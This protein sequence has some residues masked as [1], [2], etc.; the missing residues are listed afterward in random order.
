M[1]LRFAKIFIFLM[2]PISVFF[3]N[4]MDLANSITKK[5]RHTVQVH[6]PSNGDYAEEFKLIEVRDDNGLSVSFSMKVK[7]VICFE[8]VCKVIPIWIRWNNLGEYESYARVRGAKLE[9]YEDDFF[10]KED[11]KKLDSILSNIDSPFRDVEP[12]QIL[13]VPDETHNEVD[14]VSGATALELDEKDTVPGAAL[15]C[16]T[17]WHWAH[18]EII[19]IIRQKF[20]ESCDD[21]DFNT[22]L[23]GDN[24]DYKYFALEKLTQNKTYSEKLIHSAITQGTEHSALLKPVITYFEEASNAVYFQA[25]EELFLKGDQKQRI[26]ALSSLL[27]TKKLATDGYFEKWHQYFSELESYQE[28]SIFLR[29]IEN[30][31]PNSKGIIKYALP[32]LDKELIIARR[33]YWF[34]NEQYLDKE[35]QKIIK[36]FFKTH[37][38]QL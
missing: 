13:T 21:H 8:A 4:R 3:Q 29:I 2:V 18:G 38:E 7:S 16:Y 32:M 33:V 17:L 24:D 34:L 30:K 20:S 25:I 22:F 31:N 36:K 27:S 19:S 11:Y 6:H 28:V 35:Q 1:I 37:K 12:D 14:A 5:I 26:L 15:T 9:K 23:N 10:T